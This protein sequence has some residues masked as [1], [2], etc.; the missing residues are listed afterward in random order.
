MARQGNFYEDDEPLD[1][2]EA[3][4]ERGRKTVSTATV[5]ELKQGW[6]TTISL[7]EGEPSDWSRLGDTQ[8]A[9]AR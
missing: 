9:V 2:L 5:G 7:P 3:A 8:A 6:N 4:F 1:K